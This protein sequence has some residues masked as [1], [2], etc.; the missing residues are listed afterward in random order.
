MKVPTEPLRWHFRWE[1]AEDLIVL[2]PCVG[3]GRGPL[4]LVVFLGGGFEPSRALWRV[5]ATRA[6]IHWLNV[7]QT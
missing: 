1:P 7:G 6:P 2:Q 4:D 3:P 5:R